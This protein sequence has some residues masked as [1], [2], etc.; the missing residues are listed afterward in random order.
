[1]KLSV[2]SIAALLL[3]TGCACTTP[4]LQSPPLPANLKAACKPAELLREGADMGDLLQVAVSSAYGLAEC[5]ARHQ[6]V[7]EFVEVGK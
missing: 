4:P 7:V 3:L 2:L 1:M 5:S 6:A